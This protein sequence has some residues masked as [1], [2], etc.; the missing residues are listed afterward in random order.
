MLYIEVFQSWFSFYLLHTCYASIILLEWIM[1]NMKN[2]WE[3]ISINWNAFHEED[4]W[5]YRLDCKINGEIMSTE[6]NI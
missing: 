3:E 2:W 6:Q 4:C 5:M 1:D